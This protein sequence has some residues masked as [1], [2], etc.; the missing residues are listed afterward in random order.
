MD[1][2]EALPPAGP[3]LSTLT[4]GVAEPGL[5]AMTGLRSTLWLAQGSVRG[6]VVFIVIIFALPEA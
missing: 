3:G 1:P 4:V 2:T 6:Y 5:C